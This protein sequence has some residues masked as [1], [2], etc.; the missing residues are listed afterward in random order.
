MRSKVHESNILALPFVARDADGVELP[1][2]GFTENQDISPHE[3]SQIEEDRL[4]SLNQDELIDLIRQSPSFVDHGKD[5]ACLVCFQSGMPRAD[6]Q[7]EFDICSVCNGRFHEACHDLWAY[8]VE[9]VTKKIW[10]CGQCRT[11][12]SNEIS[13]KLMETCAECM[14][15]VSSKK[16]QIAKLTEDKKHRLRLLNLSIIRENKISGNVMKSIAHADKALDDIINDVQEPSSPRF[17]YNE[18]EPGREPGTVDSSKYSYQE[19]QLFS[20]DPNAKSTK[21]QP[22]LT[23]LISDYKEEVT[24]LY[25]DTVFDPIDESIFNVS[26]DWTDSRMRALTAGISTLLADVE[27]GEYEVVRGSIDSHCGESVASSDEPS[28]LRTEEVEHAKK[29]VV[30]HPLFW[31]FETSN[32]VRGACPFASENSLWR[33][34]HNLKDIMG[35]CQCKTGQL[36]Q[37][38]DLIHHLNSHT[39]WFAKLAANVVE[40]YNRIMKD[41]KPSAVHS[42]PKPKSLFDKPKSALPSNQTTP[43]DMDIDDHTDEMQDQIDTDLLANNKEEEDPFNSDKDSDQVSISSGSLDS[44]VIKDKA[45]QKKRISNGNSNRRSSSRIAAQ[46]EKMLAREDDGVDDSSSALSVAE[47]TDLDET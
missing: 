45:K 31:P 33:D 30:C 8:E 5:K 28:Y 26:E 46:R 11:I 10:V 39:H 6:G 4:Q 17:D 36:F 7:P 21:S 41:T 38:E 27:A 32:K 42:P 2:H 15:W 3:H 25:Q 16:E 35:A 18:T 14:K 19:G 22:Q 24:Y 37:M 1:T 13:I 47:S 43:E 34:H 23:Q 9:G 44:A 40:E 29:L 12:R 20:P